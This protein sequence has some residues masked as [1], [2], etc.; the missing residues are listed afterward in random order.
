MRRSSEEPLL[1]PI[2]VLTILSLSVALAGAS[3]QQPTPKMQLPADRRAYIA[4][5]AQL[6]PTERLAAM[7]QFLIDYPTS[8]RAGRARSSILDLLLAYF[9]DKTS[10][11]DAQARLLIKSSGKGESRINEEITVA[12]KL[13]EAA[14]NGI[15]LPLAEKLAKEAA[16]DQEAAFSKQ[17]V[18]EYTK[19]KVPP[20]S[21]AEIH[22]K[23]IQQESEALSVV[24]EVAFH[25]GKL[26]KAHTIADQ[27]FATDPT[28]DDTNSIRGEIA[29]ATH[30]DA[31][32]LDAFER[33]QL[34][35]GLRPALRVKMLTLYSAAHNNS[36]ATFDADQDARY[37]KLFPPPFTPTPHK[38]TTNGHTV[39]V[40]L[41]TGSACEPCVGADLALE[42][43]LASY[44]RTDVVVLSLDQH[45]PA[46]DPLANPDSVARATQYDI[47]YTPTFAIDGQTLEATG[48]DRSG[49]EDLY[50]S[51]A[52]SIDANVTRPSAAQLQLT[53][54][55]TPDGQ[56]TAQAHVTLGSEDKLQ[57]EIATLPVPPPPPAKPDAK[58]TPAAT[59]IASA[60][61]PPTPPAVPSLTLNFALVE[62]D[63]RYSGE[64]G[65][66]FHHMVV[67]AFAK[68][69]GQGFPLTAGASAT[70][71]ASFQPAEISRQL[72]TYLDAFEKHNERFENAHF[73][74]KNTAIDP[75]HLKVVAWIEDTADH[76]ILQTTF[77]SLAPTT[78][79]G[80]AE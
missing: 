51:L 29:L 28:V 17:M 5:R 64:N 55:I 54:A 38:P 52:K 39:L 66:R 41:F 25:Q 62:D 20:P 68:P 50:K 42:A 7:R 21:A 16:S 45:I 77:V 43:M 12:Q 23:F 56:V 73:L 61:A 8:N 76:R 58:A 70:L 19:A 1:A 72:T 78:T 24:A 47:R 40:E 31:D 11:I 69:A 63:V 35:G 48:G 37:A 10:E 57:S 74:N 75:A 3:A 65:I 53:A 14:P 67:R 30:R 13:A 49:S 27:A 59:P 44:P 26:D 60:T 4:A 6:D 15:D 80:A 32:A 71:D 22:T 33:A 2:R 18:E 79:T 9:P 34:Y 46:P 36:D